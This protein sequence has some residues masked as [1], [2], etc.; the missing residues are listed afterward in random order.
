MENENFDIRESGVVF[1]YE[2]VVEVIWIFDFE[3]FC[4]VN[5]IDVKY[6][7]VKI[8]DVSSKCELL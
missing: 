5:N 7:V 8:Y 2:V 1:L 4:D 3:V 6:D